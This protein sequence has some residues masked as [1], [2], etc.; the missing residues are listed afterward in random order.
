M[1]LAYSSLIHKE[2]S[3]IRFITKHL[4]ITKTNW[5]LTESY[6]SKKMRTTT[7]LARSNTILTRQGE[8]HVCLPLI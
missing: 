8:V 4:L 5:E 1:G 2:S 7:S 3:L 6:S